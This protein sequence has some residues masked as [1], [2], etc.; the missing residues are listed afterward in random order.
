[1]A[2]SD[3]VWQKLSGRC[4]ISHS[5]ADS[6]AV[7]ALRERL[8]GRVEPVV[9]DQVRPDPNNAVSEGIIPAILDCDCVI[10][11][12][13]G[14]SAQSFWVA[15]ESDYARRSGLDVFAY[16]PAT[17]KLREDDSDPLPL[18]IAT[19]YHQDDG[20]AVDELFAWMRDNRNFDLTQ[21]VSRLKLGNVSGDTA[22]QLQEQ[23][24]DGGVVLYLCGN[25]S[26]GT[27]DQVRDPGFWDY[28]RDVPEFWE[29]YRDAR[30]GGYRDRRDPSSPFKYRD[31]EFYSDADP[32][33]YLFGVYARVDADLPPAWQ[34]AGGSVID[35]LGGARDHRFNWNR[36]DDLIVRLYEAMLG[37]RHACE[38]S[39]PMTHAILDDQL[40]MLQL[41]WLDKRGSERLRVGSAEAET[42]RWSHSVSGAQNLVLK[43]IKAISGAGPGPGT[44]DARFD[45]DLSFDRGFPA[46]YAYVWNRYPHYHELSMDIDG[47][48]AYVFVRRVP[49][50]RRLK[51]A[52]KKVYE[53]RMARAFGK[54]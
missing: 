16:D 35:L 10:Y 28:L 11:L 36:I 9:F 6:E 17:G 25:R 32:Y 4:F 52:A 33:D 50:P 22:V 40:S 2:K 12:D 42:H 41:E 31:Y 1:M 3:E 27:I 5:Y 20:E 43:S 51:K 34:P 37:Y 44:V 14:A 18:K 30:M 23:F 47:Q 39:P 19:F 53:E 13:R 29:R 7:K 15:F 45:S 54:A 24:A 48:R 26:F 21:T 38:I 46:H 49:I 8:P